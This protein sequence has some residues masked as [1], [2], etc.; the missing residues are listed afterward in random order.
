MDPLRTRVQMASHRV[1]TSN[2]VFLP[3]GPSPA[4]VEVRQGKIAAI[5]L[6]VLPRTA[7]AGL[8][9]EDYV[10]A[11]DNWI[12]PGVSSS[13]ISILINQLIVIIQLVDAHVHLNEPGRTEWEGFAT[14]TA[15][16]KAAQPHQARTS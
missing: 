1:F 10:D 7:F 16:S 2:K 13:P 11:G 6:Q 9:E 8:D 14:G 4:T 5:H 15:V 12:L 3:S